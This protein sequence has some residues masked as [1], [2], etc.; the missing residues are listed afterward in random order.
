MDT[1]QNEKFF[2]TFGLDINDQH[3]VE[4]VVAACNAVGKLRTNNKSKQSPITAFRDFIEAWGAYSDLPQATKKRC[5]KFYLIFCEEWE[6]V[7]RALVN[8]FLSQSCSVKKGDVREYDNLCITC[9]EII[10]AL[11][12]TDGKIP[13]AA[14]LYE[15]ALELAEN[16]TNNNHAGIA[17]LYILCARI[18]SWCLRK[19]PEGDEFLLRKGYKNHMEASCSDSIIYHTEM[20]AY[21]ISAAIISLVLHKGGE[22]SDP[23]SRD[24]IAESYRMLCRFKSPKTDFLRNQ[25]Y[26]YSGLHADDVI[27]LNKMSESDFFT[28]KRFVN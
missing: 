24:M 27:D 22:T 3:T 18:W 17:L 28:K 5:E 10:E 2:N 14:K 9:M 16:K 13:D 19:T 7:A 26:T 1:H 6:D 15:A 23:E 8:S 25:I 11:A 20:Y 21:H 12:Y 4:F